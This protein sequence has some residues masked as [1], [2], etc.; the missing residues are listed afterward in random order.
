MMA[1]VNCC[2]GNS[3]RLDS[4]PST[5]NTQHEWTEEGDEVDEVDVLWKDAIKQIEI[6]QNSCTRDHDVCLKL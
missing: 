4:V 2:H 6:L 3:L 1:A 5:S